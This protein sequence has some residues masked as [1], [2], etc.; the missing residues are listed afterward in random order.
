MK[1]TGYI[2]ETASYVALTTVS[3]TYRHVSAMYPEGYVAVTAPYVA[4]T[5]DTSH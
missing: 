5:T 4:L 1:S 3:A 2:A